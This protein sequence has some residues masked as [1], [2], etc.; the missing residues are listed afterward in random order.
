MVVAKKAGTATITVTNNG[1]STKFTV[2]VLNPSLDIGDVTLKRG[3]SV[4]IGIEG[5]IG[6]AEFTSTNSKVATVNSKGKIVAKKKGNA[7]IKVKTNGITL[8]CNVKV[9]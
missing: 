4:T 9:K 1:V 6:K 3:K 8:K 5:Q 2:T 7:V